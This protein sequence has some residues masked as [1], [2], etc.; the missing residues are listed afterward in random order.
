MVWGRKKMLE[1][2]GADAE[3]GTTIPLKMLGSR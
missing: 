1:G 3:I 2:I